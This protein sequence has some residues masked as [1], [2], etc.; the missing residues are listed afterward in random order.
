VLL[1]PTVVSALVRRDFLGT[2]SYRLAFVLDI[3]YGVL[4]LVLYFFISN[5]FKHVSPAGLRGA[6]SYFAFAA[7]GIILGAVLNATSSGV[8]YRMREE[9]VSGT[10]EAINAEPVT[11]FELCIG[12]VG[13]PFA[14]AMARASLYLVVAAGLLHLDVSETSWAGLMLVLLTAAAA[15]A[16]IGI[17]AGAAVLV[18]KRGHVVA[19]TMMYLMTIL[20]GMLFPVSVLPNWLEPLAHIVPLTYAFNGARDALFTGSGWGTDVLVLAA[21]AIVLWPL[22]LSLFWHALAYAKRVGSLAQY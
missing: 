8:G 10:L 21:W 5:T 14:F 9:Q 18:F 13:F 6:P 16:P 7:A 11:L 2:R 12:L 19:G 4:D 15:I 20:A 22:S 1:R 17:I 3:F